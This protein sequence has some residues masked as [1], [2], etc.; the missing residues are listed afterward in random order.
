MMCAICV[1][2]D[3]SV[4]ITDEG[5]AGIELRVSDVSK[6]LPGRATRTDR[7]QA[8]SGVAA[9]SLEVLVDQRL[10]Q[11]ALV[12][13]QGPLFDQDPIQRLRLVEATC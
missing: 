8:P 5:I 13:A 10:Q 1:P 2:F 4:E 9:V 6:S 3:A 11:V 12:G 7:R